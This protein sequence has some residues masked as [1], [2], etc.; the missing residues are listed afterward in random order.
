MHHTATTNTLTR[1]SLQWRW[2]D[3]S[4]D[5]EKERR[6]KEGTLSTFF[7]Q[8][9]NSTMTNGSELLPLFLFA[10]VVL[11]NA[12]DL[13][14]IFPLHCTINIH[15]YTSTYSLIH[16]HTFPALWMHFYC[17]SHF[18]HEQAYCNASTLIPFF[19]KYGFIVL[20]FSTLGVKSRQDAR[21]LLYFRATIHC[22]RVKLKPNAL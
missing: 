22:E 5:G 21:E 18:G 19:L 13:Q 12:T 11:L 16:S 6:E 8:P 1:Q 20:F 7:G 14:P 15:F 17:S 2:N 3:F 9:F 4:S 10:A